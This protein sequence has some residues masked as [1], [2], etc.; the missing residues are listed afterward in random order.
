M[1]ICRQRADH[2]AP[3]M[4]FDL[5][6]WRFHFIRRRLHYSNCI[7]YNQNDV[8]QNCISSKNSQLIYVHNTRDRTAKSVLHRFLLKEDWEVKGF[9]LVSTPM[10]F[11]WNNLWSV[12]RYIMGL[13]I[14]WCSR[15]GRT[16]QYLIL[17]FENVG[18]ELVITDSHFSWICFQIT[19]FTQIWQYCSL[20][21]WLKKMWQ[22]W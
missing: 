19:H 1:V 16:S 11:F 8:T 5:I 4:R 18:Q 14:G 3:M 21:I 10:F 12:S 2:F 20:G 22:A 13:F 7:K 9:L 15:M 6:R 17:P